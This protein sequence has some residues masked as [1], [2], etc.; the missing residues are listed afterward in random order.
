MFGSQALDIY[1]KQPTATSFWPQKSNSLS[2]NICYTIHRSLSVKFFYIFYRCNVLT[3]RVTCHAKGSFRSKA[4]CN[5]PPQGAE[6]G[7]PGTDQ[8]GYDI[9]RI[10]ESEI[11]NPWALTVYVPSDFPPRGPLQMSKSLP[12]WSFRNS[13]CCGFPASPTP[14]LGKT[15]I[16]AQT[17]CLLKHQHLLIKYA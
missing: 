17:F 9:I 10:T 14:P 4:F 5:A 2:A 16:G 7:W 13:N 12:W 8:K 6:G 3:V 15:S 11:S 1:L